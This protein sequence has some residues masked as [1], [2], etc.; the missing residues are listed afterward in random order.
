MDV[1]VVLE[2]PAPGVEDTGETREI[3]P[4][5]ALVF[6]QPLESRCRRLKHG[7]VREALLRADEGSE[8]LRHGEGEQEVRPGQLLLQVVGEPLLGFMLLT[9]RAM[10]IA[11]GM[12]DVVFFPTALA[13]IEAVSIVSAAAILD[14]ADDL[15]VRGGEVGRT[16]QGR[17][18]TGGA[19][20][21]QGGHG[22][23][24]C[25]RALRRA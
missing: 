4:D 25:M 9:L 23:S 15:T 21:A 20:V 17:W 1:G 7:L 5:E 22:R 2:L 18:R 19:E 11:T 24:P 13:L 16:R 6:G 8:R 10:T 3:G 14:G 12:I